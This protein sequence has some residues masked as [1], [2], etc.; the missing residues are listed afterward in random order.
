MKNITTNIPLMAVLLLLS[1]SSCKV[2]QPEFRRVEN[3]QLNRDGANFTIGADVVCYNPNRFRFKI[4]NLNA[5]VFFNDQK[6][7]M[8]GKE[9]DLK[10]KGRSEFSVP[11]SITFTGNDAFKNLFI[12][13]S[14]IIKKQQMSLLILG[15]VKFKAYGVIKKEFPFRYEKNLDMNP[16]K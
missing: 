1:F 2:S 12:N 9:M 5:N 16:F 15:N 6:M 14:Q 13:L 3:Y 10:V 7:T 8:L 4:Q 11:L